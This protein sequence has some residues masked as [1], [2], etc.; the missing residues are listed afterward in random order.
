[1]IKSPFTTNKYGFHFKVW[2]KQDVIKKLNDICASLYSGYSIDKARVPY[3]L[4]QPFM[5]NTKEYKVACYAGKFEYIVSSA[6][7]HYVTKDTRAF[8]MK[9]H[10]RLR[11]FVEEAI[12][13]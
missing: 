11:I 5:K 13:S 6:S 3:M 2:T 7:P 12:A 4:I 9:P 1:M 8:T 10:T